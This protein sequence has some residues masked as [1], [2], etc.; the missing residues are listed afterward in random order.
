MTSQTPTNV[1]PPDRRFEDLTYE[2]FRKLAVDPA[3]SSYE[4]VGFP[5]AY[6]QGKD[7]AILHDILGKVTALRGKQKTVLDIGPGCSPLAQLLIDL[8]EQQGHTLLLIDSPEMLDHLPDRPFLHKVPGYFPRCPDLCQRY[9]GRV[10]A[11]LSYSVTQ[12][13]FVD[14][15]I[16]DFVDRA[17]LLLA[18][19]G[20][21]F[22][23]DIPNVSKRK[24]FFSSPA[25]VKYH[26]AC[27]GRVEQPA[28]SF[29]QPE[30][31]KIDDAVILALLGRARLAGYDSYLLPQRTDLP[32]SNRRE[33][34]LI[35][36]P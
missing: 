6:R 4:K 20:E 7:A 35:R 12:Y 31:G 13:A 32:M 1:P 9:A 10:D 30:T 23:G 3:L 29:N 24:R 18:P 19:G 15:N 28:V 21:L 8:C 11:I 36:K 22:L 25:G 5:D 34:V 17:M 27:V 2:D 33:D 16:F 14:G 26:Q